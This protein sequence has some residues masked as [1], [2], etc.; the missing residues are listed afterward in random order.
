M[1]QYFKTSEGFGFNEPLKLRLINHLQHYIT[2]REYDL[3]TSCSNGLGWN[4]NIFILPT[5]TSQQNLKTNSSSIVNTT[6]PLTTNVQQMLNNSV[7]SSSPITTLTPSSLSNHS[8]SSIT[9][10]SSSSNYQQQINQQ[11]QQQQQDST[12]TSPL[13]ESPISNN[14]SLNNSSQL[15]SSNQLNASQLLNQHSYTDNNNNTSTSSTSSN[16]SL[17]SESS[18]SHSTN[19]TSVANLINS[20]DERGNL[21]SNNLLNVSS[22][23]MGPPPPP[24]Q[25]VAVFNGVLPHSANAAELTYTSMSNMHPN[26]SSPYS[27]HP[28]SSS[29]IKMD[30]NPIA[31]NNYAATAY[32][33]HIHNTQSYFNSALAYGTVGQKMANSASVVLQPNASQANSQQ[34]IAAKASY[35]RPWNPEIV[36]GTY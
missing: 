36:G 7:A 26:N 34:Y 23:I 30:S 8:N 35:C 15:N 12:P 13:C 16:N 18:A 4:P 9:S 1:A 24:L 3:K 11:Q 5:T 19:Q 21:L 14:S 33:N 10:N 6:A 28:H 22:S 32:A 29:F 20:N 31:T 27:H 2:Q 17:H 25:K